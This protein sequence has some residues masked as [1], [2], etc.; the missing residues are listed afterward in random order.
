MPGETPA[1]RPPARRPFRQ[2]AGPQ[3]GDQVRP[4]RRVPPSGRSAPGPVPPGCGPACCSRSR[5]ERLI[6]DLHGG[7]NGLQARAAFRPRRLLAAGPRT[8]IEERVGRAAGRGRPCSRGNSR[9]VA[10]QVG[11]RRRPCPAAASNSASAAAASRSTRCRTSAA[12]RSSPAVPSM[13][14]TSA[15][16]IRSGA[17]ARSC[18]SSDWLSRIEPAARRASTSR[19]S[20]SASTPSAATICRSRS[21]ID[22]GG[23]A[24]EI[25]PLAARQDR[26]RDLRR[27]GRAEDELHMLRRLFQRLQQGVEGLAGEH[28]DFVD[29]VDLEPRPAGP[30]VDVLPQLA[31]FVDA[32]VAGPV[33]LQHVDVVARS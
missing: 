32:A 21:K 12:S 26:D 16:V 4:T 31:D 30:H 23:N 2:R 13:P 11:R 7:Q 28:V 24:G 8:S 15:T 27:L 25:E 18:S 9:R 19:A 20:G 5:D 33:D 10:R 14:W 17:K 3:L 29:D 1:G 22:R 6:E